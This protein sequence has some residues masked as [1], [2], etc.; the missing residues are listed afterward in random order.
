MKDILPYVR[1][2]GASINSTKEN[3]KLY[4]ESTSTFSSLCSIRLTVEWTLSYCKDDYPS[5]RVNQIFS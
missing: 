1:D 3:L 4:I 2:F 5:N